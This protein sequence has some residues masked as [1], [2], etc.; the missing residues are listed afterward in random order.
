[1]KDKGAHT[2]REENKQATLFINKGISSHI[3]ISSI[4]STAIL[5][6][7]MFYYCLPKTTH[8]SGN[9]TILLRKESK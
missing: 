2:L 6:T 9:T 5:Y 7:T 1:M 3:A 8:T 4:C